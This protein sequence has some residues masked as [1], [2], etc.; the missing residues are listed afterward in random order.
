MSLRGV[1]SSV[2]EE[3]VAQAGNPMKDFKLHDH[4]GEFVHCV[5]FG[6]HVDNDCIVDRNEIVLF[7]A[8]GLAGLNSGQGQLWMYDDSHIVLL[9]QARSFA[10]PRTC[11]E[12]RGR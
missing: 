3:V 8:K 1:I 5:A 7:F 6:R 10:P 12:L 2:Q 4:A 9:G 11:M